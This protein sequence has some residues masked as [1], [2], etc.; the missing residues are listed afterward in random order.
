MFVKKNR[1]KNFHDEVIFYVTFLL[2]MFLREVVDYMLVKKSREK[3]KKRKEL[4]VREK[5]SWKK[6]NEDIVVHIISYKYLQRYLRSQ[7]F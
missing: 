1:E 7:Y 4:H 3:R 5:N 6:L 2:I